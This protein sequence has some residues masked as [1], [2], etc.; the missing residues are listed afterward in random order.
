MSSKIRETY[1]TNIKLRVNQEWNKNKFAEQIF[2]IN[3]TYAS[4]NINKFENPT[5]TA[6][7]SETKHNRTMSNAQH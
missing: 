5:F 2:N 6:K 7:R 4:K 1:E 3:I